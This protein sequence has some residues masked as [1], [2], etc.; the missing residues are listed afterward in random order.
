MA[1]KV[2]HRILT[3]AEYETALD[4]VER[5]FDQEP[6]PGTPEAER[7]D[8]LTRAIESYEAEHWAVDGAVTGNGHA[9]PI[10]VRKGTA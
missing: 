1:N 2:I 7:F 9:K 10:R 5:Y 6:A 3:E 8:E 4:E